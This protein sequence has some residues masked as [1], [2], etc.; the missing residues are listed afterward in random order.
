MQQPLEEPGD[1]S[2]APG[3]LRLVQLFVNTNDLET[4]PDL[5][6]DAAALR[7]WFV[8]RGLLAPDAPVT[9]GD[10]ARA[11]ALREAIREL[12]SAHA[13]LPHDP[14]AGEIV[15][16]VGARAGLHPVLD[17]PGTRIEPSA[18]GVDGALGRIVAAIHAGVAEGTWERLKACERDVCRWAFYDHSKNRSSHWCSMAVCGQR[19]KNRRAYRRRRAAALANP[20]RG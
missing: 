6:P 20:A 17:D 12:V 15:N 8:D 5:L 9:D 14:A 16:A 2:P 1:R 7:N 11:I 4:G 13:G 3:S 19:E 18:S 10:H